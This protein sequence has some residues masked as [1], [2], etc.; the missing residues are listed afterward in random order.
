MGSIHTT[1]GNRPQRWKYRILTIGISLLQ[2]TLEDFRGRIWPFNTWLRIVIRIMRIFLT[3]ILFLQENLNVVPS[4][5]AMKSE[6]NKMSDFG[7]ITSKLEL[8]DW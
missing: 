6:D 7:K 2:G 5:I 1:P 4:G 3:L 8:S